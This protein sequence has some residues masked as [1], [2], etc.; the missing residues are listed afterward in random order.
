[1]PDVV[2]L[3]W[4]KGARQQLAALLSHLVDHFCSLDVL[5]VL[6][7]SQQLGP[8]SRLDESM[9]NARNAREHLLCNLLLGKKRNAKPLPKP[10]DKLM[11]SLVQYREQLDALSGALWSCQQYVNIP[12]AENDYQLVAK[13]EWWSQVK[14]LGATCRALEN[15]IGQTFFLTSPEDNEDGV[16]DESEYME[17][18]QGQIPKESGSYEHGP[19]GRESRPAEKKKTTSQP[20]RWSS[21]GKG[22]W[23]NFP[24]KLV[25]EGMVEM[26]AAMRK[27]CLYLSAMR[28]QSKC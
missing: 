18:N 8:R 20:R 1:M 3:T 10:N 7:L 2:D 26:V 11:L 9:W 16:R 19:D 28:Y 14:Q 6:A 25:L 27:P 23:L 22:R 17:G 24:E 5:L 21:R 15:E 4:I 13:S 12:L